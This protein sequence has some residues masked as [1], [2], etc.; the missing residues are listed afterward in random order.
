MSYNEQRPRKAG[1]GETL[2]SGSFNPNNTTPASFWKGWGG[3]ASMAPPIH[4]KPQKPTDT[5][6]KPERGRR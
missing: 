1:T 4:R 2:G 6:W 3:P 5:W